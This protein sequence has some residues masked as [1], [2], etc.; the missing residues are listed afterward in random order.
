MGIRKYGFTRGLTC[1]IFVFILCGCASTKGIADKSGELSSEDR[2]KFDYFYLEAERLKAIGENDAAFDLMSRAADLDTTS[3]AA[4]F[5]LDP[6]YLRMGFYEQARKDLRY[7]AEKYPDNY[8]YNVVYANFS[9]QSNRHDEAIRIWT[10]L[11]EQNPDKPEIN[12]ALAEAYTAKGD[13]KQA[14]ACYDRME[15]SMGMMEPITIEKLKLYEYMGDKE[16]MVAE[17]EK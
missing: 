1:L 13:M 9:Q 16:A 6:Y 17:A 12:S 5:F 7:A 14:V 10:R 4:R 15:S 3:A 8:W 11:L 2:R